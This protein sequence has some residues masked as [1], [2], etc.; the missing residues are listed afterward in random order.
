MENPWDNPTIFGNKVELDAAL[1]R[2]RAESEETPGGPETGQPR[3]EKT[4]NESP[5]LDYAPDA[6]STGMM[7]APGWEMVYLDEN[8]QE[9]TARLVGWALTEEGV[10]RGLIVAAT[11]E[12][13]FGDS[14]E[15]FRGY[16]DRGENGDVATA[17]E[18][19]NTTFANLAGHPS[20][21]IFPSAPGAAPGPGN[22]SET[23][24]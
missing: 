4:V 15:N 11:G 22:T 17:L 23:M 21:G 24:L 18:A 10:V 20:Q 3:E 9:A 13:V 12:V 16:N 8:G 1:D 7:P 2:I 14:V 19:L 5:Q 6:A